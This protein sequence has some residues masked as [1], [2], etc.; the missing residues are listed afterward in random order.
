MVA[1]AFALWAGVTASQAAVTV[2]SNTVPG[3]MLL[4]DGMG[5][6]LSS[7]EAS[8]KTINAKVFEGPAEDAEFLRTLANTWPRE[9]SSYQLAKWLDEVSRM[10]AL[11]GTALTRRLVD[12][13]FR[14]I[15]RGYVALLLG[16]YR[17][18][19]AEWVTHWSANETPGLN[20]LW[21]IKQ[22]SP[23]DQRGCL[24]QFR[25]TGKVALPKRRIRKR[26]NSESFK[27]P[28]GNSESF[29]LA[30]AARELVLA[31]KSIPELP[32]RATQAVAA[33]ET[34]LSKL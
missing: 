27:P 28:D 19:V 9:L 32:A 6:L 34:A 1:L 4:L 33:L 8:W 31:C 20:V 21:R 13:G 10:Y 22:L 29:G 30:D 12:R 11:D 24:E 25:Q 26:R 18:L 16:T 5:R 7:S 3:D 2:E 23:E 15:S 17:G 14:E